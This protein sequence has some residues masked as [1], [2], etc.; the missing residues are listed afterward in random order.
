MGRAGFLGLSSASTGSEG[1]PLPFFPFLF[2]QGIFQVVFFTYMS[3]SF[4]ESVELQVGQCMD[5]L[6]RY[7]CAED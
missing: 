2:K 1:N 3:A 5:E 4:E 7:T 6:L